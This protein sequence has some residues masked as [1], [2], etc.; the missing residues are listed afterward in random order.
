MGK[1]C[2]REVAKN[3]NRKPEGKEYILM[4]KV[5]I[6]VLPFELSI[7]GSYESDIK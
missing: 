2:K 5:L 1:L 3:C 7:I 6:Q 4:R